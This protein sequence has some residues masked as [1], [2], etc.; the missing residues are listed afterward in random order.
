MSEPDLLQRQREILRTFH[1][2]IARRVQAEAE[3]KAV[4]DESQEQAKAQLDRIHDK[5]KAAKEI[6]KERRQQQA[7]VDFKARPTTGLQGDDPAQRIKRCV[8]TAQRSL[9]GLK[10]AKM[11]G[12]LMS[13]LVYLGTMCVIAPIVAIGYLVCFALIPKSDT[14]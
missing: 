5:L 6:L 11:P 9:E 12:C 2:A 3:A 10:K 13:V 8:S 7:L 1:Q 4:L 14:G